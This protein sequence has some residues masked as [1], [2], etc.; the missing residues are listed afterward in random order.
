MPSYEYGRVETEEPASACQCP[1]EIACS[2][3]VCT[4]CQREYCNWLDELKAAELAEERK[5]AA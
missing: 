5:A 4:A 1:K 3:D 2:A